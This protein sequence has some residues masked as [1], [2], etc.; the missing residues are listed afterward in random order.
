MAMGRPIITTDANGCRE[1][2]QDGKNGFLVPIKDAN[3]VAEAMLRFV[4]HPELIR[5]M[6]MDSRRYCEEKFEVN[7]VNADMLKIIG[8]TG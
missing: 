4:E 1:T 6:G 3:A 8:I 2:V 5:Q 7:K